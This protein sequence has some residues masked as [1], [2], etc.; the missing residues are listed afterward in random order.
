MNSSYFT[1]DNFFGKKIIKEDNVLYTTYGTAK[2]LDVKKGDFIAIKFTYY[3]GYERIESYINFKVAGFLKP[4]Y[5]ELT[6]SYAENKGF[7][8]L[9]FLSDDEYQKLKSNGMHTSYIFFTDTEQDNKLSFFANTKVD[10]KESVLTYISTPDSQKRI[11]TTLLTTVAVIIILIWFEFS[12]T[13]RKNRKDIETL[14]KLGMHTKTIRKIYIT[15][16]FIS[17]TVTVILALIISKFIYLDKIVAIYCDP[18]LL[19][20]LLIASLCLGFKSV[21]IQSFIIKKYN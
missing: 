9:A 21:I 1:K 15:N 12:F 20:L 7:I 14:S 18:Q 13:R 2:A 10:L 11:A 16:I 19:I 4:L 6:L 3:S 5:Y 8:S 17:Y